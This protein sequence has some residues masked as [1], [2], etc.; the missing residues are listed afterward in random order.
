[1]GLMAR[2][3]SLRGATLK[4]LPESIGPA[5]VVTGEAGDHLETRE[6]YGPPGLW[7]LPP[8]GTKGIRLSV[9]GSERYGV[10]VA[11]HHYQTS[12]P[13]LQKG[14]T[15]IGSTTA[16]GSTVQAKTVYKADGTQELNGDS[17]RLVTWQELQ[18]A[19]TT[20][21]ATLTAHVH[22]SNG[23]PSPGLV[24]L[25]CDISGAQT[26]TIKTGG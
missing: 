14:E 9:G 18:T 15:A 8:D 22:P 16:D 20:L 17:K 13:D 4:T 3:L 7:Y 25:G 26:T 11:T 23:A 1:M 10:I 6:V 21:C 24:G 12:R 19:L 2:M 5:P